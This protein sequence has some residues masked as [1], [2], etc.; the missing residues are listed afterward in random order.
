[1]V[2]RFVVVAERDHVFEDFWKWEVGKIRRCFSEN[3]KSK[4][5]VIFWRAFV[6][7]LLDEFRVLCMHAFLPL[8]NL[9]EWEWDV[10]MLFCMDGW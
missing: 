10:I 6:K 8:A 1:L 5:T 7:Q 9:Q 2:V 4:L 3:K